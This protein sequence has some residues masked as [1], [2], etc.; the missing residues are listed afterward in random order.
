MDA[1]DEFKLCVNQA[2]KELKE[3]I[4]NKKLAREEEKSRL[5]KIRYDAGKHLSIIEQAQVHTRS[6]SKG[7]RYT[8]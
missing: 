8:G 2:I 6:R 1:Q 7:V 5:S 3:K 4:G